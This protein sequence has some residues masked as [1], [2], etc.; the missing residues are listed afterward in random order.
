MFATA[1]VT[2]VALSLGMVATPDAATISVRASVRLAPDAQ[3]VLLRDIAHLEGDAAEAL[4]EVVIGVVPQAGATAEFSLK[5]I[6][7][8]LDEAGVHW[9]RTHLNGRSVV[10]RARHAGAASAP[11]PMAPVSL[12]QAVVETVVD[13]ERRE[14]TPELAL[15]LL[16]DNDLRSAVAEF[17]VENL[18]VEPD[19]L[20]LTFDDGDAEFL[21]LPLATNRFELAPISSLHSNRIELAIRKW[22]GERVSERKTINVVP[23][24]RTQALTVQRDLSRGEV[25]SLADLDLREQWLGPGLMDAALGDADAVVGRTLNAR[26]R[27][28]DVLRDSHLQR[29]T[30]VRRGEL[31]MVRC[32]VGG[33]VISLQAE[34]RASAAIGDRIEFRKPGERETF[35]ATVTGRGAAVVDLSRRSK[36]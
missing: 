29:E 32:I 5:Q 34:A 23:V 30:I 3:H 19:D 14:P 6:R 22:D 35:L 24:V 33:A 12:N 16:A 25:L 17:L 11:L 1:L 27:E 13:R 18:C 8:A 21:A 20:Q 7:D 4:A 9:G 28:G 2:T 15:T 26:L 36:Q 31:V 10:V